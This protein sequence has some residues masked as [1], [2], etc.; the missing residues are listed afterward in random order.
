M[1]LITGG[2]G[3]IGSHTTLLLLNQGYELVVLDN[4]SNSSPES[5][6][7]VAQLTGKNIPFV[8]GDIRDRALLDQLFCDYPIN[9]VMNFAGLKAVGESV[10]KPLDYYH[11]NVYGA[12]VLLQAMQ[13][14]KIKT[15][16]FSS[17]AT[18]Y[19]D[20]IQNPIDENYPTQSPTNPYGATKLMIER[21][22]SDVVRADNDWNIAILRYFNPIGAHESGEIGEDPNGIPNNLLP[23]IARVATGV[24]PHLSVFGDDYPTQD[25]TGVR[26]YIHVMDLAQG[27]L[28][29]L[30]AI[31]QKKGLHIWNLGTGTG[32]S[33]LE[34]IHA[35]ERASGKNIPYQIAPRRQGDIAMCYANPAKAERE[36]GWKAT[37]DL[38]TM[39]KD[40]WRWQTKNPNGYR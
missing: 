13:E 10:A 15:F 36:L 14:A 7:R 33:V 26:D 2:A 12:T 17:S 38:E 1:I 16:V 40:T 28:D 34:I 18:V 23:Y 25:G 35:F 20:P 9:A 19:G 5:L 31:E 21:M 39:M 32:Y 11:C 29:A 3:Y 4:L 27:H 8:K 22:L 37:R 30:N 24:F 6:R